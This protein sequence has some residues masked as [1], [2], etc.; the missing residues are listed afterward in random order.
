MCLFHNA[1]LQFLEKKVIF[2]HSQGT[3]YL[4]SLLVQEI[5]INVQGAKFFPFE[6]KELKSQE[7]GIQQ[8][9]QFKNR[10]FDSDTLLLCHYDVIFI[11]RIPIWQG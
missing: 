9:R 2:V 1:L 4:I 3:L 10:L 7:R 11:Y 6:D 8:N 5:L